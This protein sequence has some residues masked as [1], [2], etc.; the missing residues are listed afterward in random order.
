M[1][2]WFSIAMNKTNMAVSQKLSGTIALVIFCA[3]AI[4]STTVSRGQTTEASA[5]VNQFHADTTHPLVAQLPGESSP[6]NGLAPAKEALPITEDFA[7]DS[8]FTL[9]QGDNHTLALRG[10]YGQFFPERTIVA[11][12]NSDEVEKPG[13]LY[14]KV[15]FTF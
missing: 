7:H 12:S 11:Q 8:S 4:I 3:V 2:V 5:P 9:L 1:G 14:L 6:P 15:R 13:W 10:G